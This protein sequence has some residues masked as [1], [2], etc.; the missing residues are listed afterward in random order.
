MDQELQLAHYWDVALRHGHC[1]YLRF[2]T[3]G[4][5]AEMLECIPNLPHRIIEKTNNAAY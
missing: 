4:D 2:P 5:I 3:Y 1:L